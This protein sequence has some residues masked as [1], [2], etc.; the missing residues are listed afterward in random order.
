MDEKERKPTLAPAT[1]EEERR[2]C[3]T[4]KRLA[5]KNQPLR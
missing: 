4:V 5:S 2:V 1:A 3:G